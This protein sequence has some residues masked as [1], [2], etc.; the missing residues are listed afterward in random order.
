MP[1]NPSQ[2][3]FDALEK[4]VW[5]EVA[6]LHPPVQQ[7]AW[8]QRKDTWYAVAASTVLL[9]GIGLANVG[10][11]ANQ[12]ESTEQ[13][14]V[15]EYLLNQTEM[16]SYELGE[17]LE[18]PTLDHLERQITPAISFEEVNQRVNLDEIF[19]ELH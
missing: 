3:Y 5:A 4:K 16:D 17:H 13:A 8:Y 15:T 7:L 10:Q 1:F 2:A 18:S 19:P 9:L 14:L 6:Q 12:G 11:T